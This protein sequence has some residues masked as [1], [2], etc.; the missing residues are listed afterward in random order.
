M[1]CNGTKL[2]DTLTFKQIQNVLQTYVQKNCEFA[3]K[4]YTAFL[5]LKSSTTG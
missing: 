1:Y 4:F 2:I 3:N 5:Y